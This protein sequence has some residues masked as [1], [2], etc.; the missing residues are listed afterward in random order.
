VP[1]VVAVMKARMDAASCTAPS[2]SRKAVTME[3]VPG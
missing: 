1:S 2:S 3:S